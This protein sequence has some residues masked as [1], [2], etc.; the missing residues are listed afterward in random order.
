MMQVHNSLREEAGDEE[1]ADDFHSNY[2]FSPKSEERRKCR[3]LCT[4]IRLMNT[5]AGML[6][7]Q[8]LRPLL[9]SPG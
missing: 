8:Q 4:L 6:S 9:P 7:F 5:C 2:N 1:S 3:M